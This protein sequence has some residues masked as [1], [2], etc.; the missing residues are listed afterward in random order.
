MPY[1]YDL[2]FKTPQKRWI[3][4]PTLECREKGHEFVKLIQERWELPTFYYH[5][6]S[7]GHVAALKVHADRKFFAKIDIKNF[8]PSISKSKVIRALKDIGINYRLSEFIASWSTVKSKDNTKKYIVPYGFVQSQIL[9]SL[10]LDKSVIG[11]FIK[12]EVP[13][14]VLVS[15]YVDDI[16]LS[17]NDASAI[18]NTYDQIIEIFDKTGFA[19]NDE[20]S[21]QALEHT[22]AF[23]IFMNANEINITDDRFEDFQNAITPL[24]TKRS[25]AIINY[26]GSVSSLQKQE[27]VDKLEAMTDTSEI[28]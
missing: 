1:N 20:K 14:E 3:F 15:V 17:S 2:C 23:N 26:V 16:I 8:F 4:V 18:Q 9:A 5:L 25:E 7:G 10:C 28:V 19:V 6:K 11:N 21:H 13:R 24:N 12:G 27:L 22:T